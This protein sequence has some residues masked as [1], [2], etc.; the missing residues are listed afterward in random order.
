ME[1]HLS[2][3]KVE[4]KRAKR[5]QCLFTCLTSR[6]V[7]LEIAYGLDT[8]LF[9]N[10]LHRTNRRGLPP[11]FISD[12]ETNFVGA[13]RELMELVAQIGQQKIQCSTTN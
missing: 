5:Y 1:N 9:L 2:Q 4:E 11:E 13:N 7:H 12:N 6:A 10:A 8:S 3:C